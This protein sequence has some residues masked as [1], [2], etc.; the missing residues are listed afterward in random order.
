MKR[1]DAAV[2]PAVRPPVGASP[3]RCLG[4]EDV[5]TDPVILSEA[6]YQTMQR[7][8]SWQE[9]LGLYPIMGPGDLGSAGLGRGSLDGAAA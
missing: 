1:P 7:G 5:E 8:T 6:D 2:D 4:R 3:H 9:A